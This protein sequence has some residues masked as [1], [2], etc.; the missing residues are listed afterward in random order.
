MGSGEIESAHRYVAQQRLKR[1]GASSTP[2]IC[3]LCGS[4][5][6]TATGTPIGATSGKNPA[7]PTTTPAKERRP[8]PPE[9]STL[10]HTH[11]FG[12]NLMLQRLGGELAV[13]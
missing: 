7:P 13:F 11:C 2:S 12:Y 4:C 1:P 10:V 3:S 6:S 9:R 5:G 8:E